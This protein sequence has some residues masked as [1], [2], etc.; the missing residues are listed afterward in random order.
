LIVAASSGL[1]WVR[2]LQTVCHERAASQSFQ[3][4]HAIDPA[5]LT[6]AISGRATVSYKSVAYIASS[7]RVIIKMLSGQGVN[8]N[9][10]YALHALDL[11]IK[12]SY[13]LS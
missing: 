4:L 6:F 1:F 3:A 12:Q 11:L 2:P 9:D 5:A 10:W 8:Q 13:L 7:R